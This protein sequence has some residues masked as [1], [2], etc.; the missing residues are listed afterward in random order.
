MGNSHVQSHVHG[1][2][3]HKPSNLEVAYFQRHPVF[4]GIFRESSE[5]SVASDTFQQPT[6]WVWWDARPACGLWGHRCLVSF[7]HGKVGP[8]TGDSCWRFTTLSAKFGSDN[9]KNWTS[10]MFKRMGNSNP[11]MLRTI[12]LA[13]LSCQAWISRIPRA[14]WVEAWEIWAANFHGADSGE[15]SLY[16]FG[17]QDHFGSFWITRKGTIYGWL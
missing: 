14:F 6:S 15:M 2:Y 13:P 5:K 16:D 11:D 9:S 7:H 1:E 12:H 17:H 3:D 4:F 8:W 10:A